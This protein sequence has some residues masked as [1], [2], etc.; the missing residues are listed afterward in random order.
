MMR[1]F[2]LAI[3]TLVFTCSAQAATST[4]I[5]AVIEV[6][7]AGMSSEAMLQSIEQQAMTACR[8]EESSVLSKLH[9]KA[10]A[11]D[12]VEQ[13]LTQLNNSE[14]NETYALRHPAKS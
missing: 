10:C 4:N 3:G 6:N 7:Q 2:A 12:L 1:A 14:L 5:Q 13:T 8:Y 11:K 9:D